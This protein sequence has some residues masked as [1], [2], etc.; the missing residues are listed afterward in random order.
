VFWSQRFTD[1]GRK[2]GDEIVLIGGLLSGSNISKTS[3][4]VFLA[5]G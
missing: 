4:A 1:K 3:K 5:F 2:G